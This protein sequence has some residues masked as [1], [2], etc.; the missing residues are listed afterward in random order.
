MKIG[1]LAEHSGTSRQTLRFYE[2]EGLLP[3]PER[4]PGG[5]RDYDPE[6]LDRLQ[7]IRSAQ[8]AGLSLREVRQVLAIRDRGE[9]P[10]GH[11]KQ[12]LADRLAGVRAQ[13]AELIALEGHLETLLERSGQ[14]PLTDHDAS[15]VCWIL[16]TAAD[17]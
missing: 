14:A 9:S 16:E 7:F 11:V 17:P 15:T 2:A 5:Y 6:T 10:C 8:A 3:E 1:E 12:L 13:I 4:T